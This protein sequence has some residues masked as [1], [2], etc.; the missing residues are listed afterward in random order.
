MNRMLKCTIVITRY[1]SSVRPSSLT[2]HIFDFFQTAAEQNT[3]KLELKQDLNVLCKV[4]P[5]GKTRLQTRPL[6]GLDIFDIS[7][8]TAERNS[9][10]LDRKQYLNVFYRV[11]V[12]RADRKK[13]GS[14][15]L[16]LTDIFDF[17][18]IV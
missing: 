6:I 16:W 9:K 18:Y 1:P 14:P 3:T 15:G 7:C 8:E 5:I 10:K 4:G 12:F 13:D 2:F 11:C 17:S